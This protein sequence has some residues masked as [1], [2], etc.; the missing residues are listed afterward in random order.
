ML[1]IIVVIIFNQS[2]AIY[3]TPH[4]AITFTSKYP[5][6]KFANR[7]SKSSWRKLIFFIFDDQ[8]LDRLLLQISSVI[9]IR[10]TTGTNSA[11]VPSGKA[12]D[13]AAMK[14][15]KLLRFF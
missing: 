1:E 15:A 8:K 13:F 2:V 5:Y 4:S 7:Q 6:S 14:T 3:I 12:R 9:E 10:H 11:D